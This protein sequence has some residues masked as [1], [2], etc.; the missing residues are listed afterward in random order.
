VAA[1]FQ[2]FGYYRLH[3]IRVSVNFYP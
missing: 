2:M 3:G 1:A